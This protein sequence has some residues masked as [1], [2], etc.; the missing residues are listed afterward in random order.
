MSKIAVVAVGGNSLISDKNHRTVPD[1]YNCVVE[2]SNHMISLI[3]KGYEV[4]LTHGNGPQVGFI[5]L[6]SDIARN[7]IHQ[8]PLDSC[9]A[10]TQGAIGYNF[11]MA[12]TNLFKKKGINKLAATI[13]TQVVV[14]EN[15][16]AFKNPSKPIGPFL[17]EADAKERQEKYGWTIMEDAGRGWRRT[18]ASP[19]PKEIVEFDVIKKLIDNK[20]V[21][22][23][24]GGGGIPVVRDKNGDLKGVAAVIDKDF[25]SG[26]LAEK[27]NADLFIISTA[28]DKVYLN[29]GKE[30]Q[31]AIDK[32]NVAEAKKYIKD[33]QFAKGSMLPKIEA[34][35]SFLEAG[36]KEVLITDPEHMYE[37]LEEK[38]GTRIHL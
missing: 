31:K 1:Q 32:M 6:R 12:L 26:L 5:L 37:A 8:V 23:A 34:A 2:T 20:M 25:A 29:F 21:V 24:V 18:V 7:H 38:N 22:M 4:V 10:D 15:D 14:D 9:V 35:I 33:G 36:G 17:E 30:N 11:Q 19:K 28:V 13:I 16:P 27:L 3:E